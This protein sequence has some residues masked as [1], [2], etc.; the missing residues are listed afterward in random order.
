MNRTQ[1]PN[2][3]SVFRIILVIPIVWA[4]LTEQFSIAAFLFIVAGISDALDGFLA[5]RYQWES[6]LGSILDPVAD[7]LLLLSSLLTLAWLGLMPGWLVWLA[8]CRDV[9]IVVGG[10]AYHHLIGRFSL[11]PLWSSK[12]NTVSQIALVA[13]IICQ[14]LY[15]VFDAAVMSMIW[16][17][18]ASILI[19]GSEYVLVWGIRAWQKIKQE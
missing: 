15:P 8:V 13:L 5:K 14:Q 9:M 1:L 10:I 16:I 2:M 19:S 12:I 4:L 18:M 3:I 17:V 11:M 6:R 7:K